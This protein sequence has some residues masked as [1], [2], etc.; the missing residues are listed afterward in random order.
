MQEL[1]DKLHVNQMRVK[2][3]IRERSYNHIVLSLTPFIML[4]KQLFSVHLAATEEVAMKE[5]K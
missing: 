5:R 3:A 4:G 2:G 1:Q